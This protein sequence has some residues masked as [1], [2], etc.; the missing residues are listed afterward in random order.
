MWLMNKQMD[1][2]SPNLMS[3]CYYYPHVIDEKTEV[4][5]RLAIF[6]GS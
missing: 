5:E 2:Y 3:K 6:V 4:L 1:E